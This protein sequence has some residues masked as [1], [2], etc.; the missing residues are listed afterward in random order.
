MRKLI[1]ILLVALP[2]AAQN[3]G[4]YSNAPVARTS[5]VRAAGSVGGNVFQDSTLVGYWPFNMATGTTTADRSGNGSAGTWS[6]TAAGTNGYWTSGKMGPYAGYFNGSNDYV[7]LGG[8]STIDVVKPMTV[9]AWV[10]FT[11][12]FS[13]SIYPRI[14]SNLTSSNY[15]GF[16]MLLNA[17]SGAH[18]NQ[19]YCQ[20][21]SAGSLANTFGTATVAPALGVWYLVAC[22]V[23]S[24]GTM[25]S[26]V[27]GASNGTISSVVIG[28]SSAHVNIGRWSGASSNYW[29]GNIQGV[30][31]YNRALS[32]AEIQAIYNAENH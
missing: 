29:T 6:G 10:T 15:N 20:T 19:F 3:Y 21:G 17:N 11:G 23:S 1:A 27:N 22:T 7:D 14:V 2:L 32:Q 25:T 8:S 26:W 4:S 30:R 12:T 13:S 5:F 31:I 18:A 16:E 28:S 9:L 24:S